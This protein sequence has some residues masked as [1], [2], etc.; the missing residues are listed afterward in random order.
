MKAIWLFPM[1]RFSCGGLA[2]FFLVMAGCGG[3]RPGEIE[4]EARA[5]RIPSSGQPREIETAAGGG[6]FINLIL[7]TENRELFG[8]P[9][10]FYMYTNRE[11][12]GVKS[13]PWE[14]G[15]YGFVRDPVRTSLGILQ[16]RLHEGM[17]IRPIR[18]DNNGEPL[19][20]VRAIAAGV[21]VYVSG[22]PRH[23]NYGRYV[24]V[25]HDWPEGAFYSLYA[26]LAVADVAREQ[27]V[28]QG[29]ILGRLGYTGDGIDKERAH[30]HLELNF[31]LSERFS[32]WYGAHYTTKNHHGIFNGINLT[33]ID[34]GR[35][36]QEYQSN[37]GLTMRDFLS[38]EEPYYRVAAPAPKIPGILRRHP[39]LGQNMEGAA[40]ALSWEITFARSGVP[41]SFSPRPKALRFPVVTWVKPMNTNHSYMTVSRL[42]GSGKTAALSPSGSRYI[43]L[44]TENF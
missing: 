27:T 22:D 40:A 30:L 4:T 12:E 23:S 43:Q 35:L 15:Q 6:K 9:T 37:P 26:H 7:P 44:I 2:C 41:L 34:V 38:R 3:P 14:G 19:D 5:E 36:Y 32:S 10:K 18:R 11:F 33:G 20:V 16:T 29:D 25:Q 8:D 31:L 13:K 28:R 42:Q 17:D 24:V 21:V 39:W 1:K